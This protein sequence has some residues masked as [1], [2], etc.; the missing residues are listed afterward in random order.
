MKKAWSKATDEQ[1]FRHRQACIA[2]G[3]WRRATNLARK[4]FDAA[5]VLKVDASAL[6]RALLCASKDELLAGTKMKTL[7]KRQIYCRG[8]IVKYA[9]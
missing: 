9:A 1:R 2:A 6:I 3:K 5:T 4:V 8:L 7:E